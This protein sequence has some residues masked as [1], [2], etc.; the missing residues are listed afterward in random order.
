VFVGDEHSKEE[1]EEEEE[2]KTTILAPLV[3]IWQE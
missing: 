2:E 3:D 1:E